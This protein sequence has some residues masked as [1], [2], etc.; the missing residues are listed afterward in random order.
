M[1]RNDLAADKKWSKTV[2]SLVVN[3]VVDEDLT[4]YGKVTQGY[5]AGT[6]N[7]G[8]VER[9][10]YLNPENGG[11]AN[12]EGTLTPA[13]PE[14][15]TAYEIGAKA[16]LLDDRIMLNSAIF[17][18]DNTNLQITVI[19]GGNVRRSLNSGESKTVGFEFDAQFA[20]TDDLMFTA[21]YGHRD[22]EYTDET[23]SDLSIY[24]ASLAMSWTMAE[25]EFGNVS[26]HADYSMNDE[27]QFSL[28]DPSMVADSY[29][30]LNARLT[31]SEIKVGD[32]SN[33]KVS[34]FGRNITDEEYVLHGASLGFF[35]TRSYGA[36]ASY[37]VD[38][39]FNF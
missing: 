30:L 20:A 36:P 19:D 13:D 24:T 9:F 21:S 8:A 17:Y 38:V 26:L 33:L 29:N 3:Y 31:L 25:L 27:F 15:T 18:N 5:A 37:G 11:E 1:L 32:K 7:S 23:F 34:V 16:M 4:V 14:D 6:F 12:Y 2:G 35:E 28:I 39:V 10:S 22:S